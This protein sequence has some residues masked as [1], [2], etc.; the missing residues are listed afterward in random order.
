MLQAETGVDV[1]YVR[2]PANHRVSRPALSLVP[3][4]PPRGEASEKIRRYFAEQP[5]ECPTLA[6]DLD[7]VDWSY[8]QL[9]WALPE[10]AIYFAVKANPAPEILD[11]LA[12]LGSRFD[13]ASR[14]EIELCLSRGIDASRLSFGNTIKKERDIAFAYS[15]GVP[16]FAIDAEEEVEKVARA[17]PGSDVFV[18]ILT[19]GAGADWPLSRKFGC[20]PAMAEDLLVMARDL[21]LNPRGVS[22]HVG[23]Q[24][25]DLDA[26]DM[27][28]ADVAAM[29]ERLDTKGIH[30]DL[31]NLGGGF[32]AR[33]RIDVRGAEAYGDAIR[34]ALA[35]RFGTR[36]ITTIAEPGRGL[37]GD[38]GAIRCEVV[39][40][41]RKDAADEARWVYLDIGK[42]SGLAETMDEAIRYRFVTSRDGDGSEAGRVVLAGPSCDSADVLYE[43]TEYRMPMSLAAGDEVMVL[44][45]GAYTSTYSSVGFNGFPPLRTVCL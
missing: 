2:T 32:P 18:R 43:K 37:V 25:G 20:S 28:L 40:V 6:V 22:F 24:Q 26:W 36:E 12:A 45:C 38:A 14:G 5:Y 35:R 19:D 15:V 42:F 34:D 27:V 44:S 29:F 7:I 16:L 11:R 3:S 13:V 4:V 41:S 23:S 8:L 39:L 17:A 21:G 30:C 33:Y 1:R 9:A 10:T 31:V